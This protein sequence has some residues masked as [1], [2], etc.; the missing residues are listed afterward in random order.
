[1]KGEAYQWYVEPL[2]E[3]RTKLGGLFDHPIRVRALGPIAAH[4]T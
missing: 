1:M 4:Y 2:S 3:A